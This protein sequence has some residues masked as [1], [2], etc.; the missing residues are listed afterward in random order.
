MLKSLTE[1][2]DERGKHAPRA[3]ASQTPGRRHRV[4]VRATSGGFACED[5]NCEA[6]R[7]YTPPHK[8]SDDPRH[9]RW[10]RKLG[11][12]GRPGPHLRIHHGELL[13]HELHGELTRASLEQG[14]EIEVSFEDDAV[15][16]HYREISHVDG[17]HILP[18]QIDVKA[19]SDWPHPISLQLIS[20]VPPPPRELGV[21]HVTASRHWFFTNI[22][23]SH[24]RGQINEFGE[25]TGHGYVIWGGSQP[26]HWETRYHCKPTP[27]MQRAALTNYNEEAARLRAGTVLH[28]GRF[29]K[30]PVITDIS[31]FFAH[32]VQQG[33]DDEEGDEVPSTL[34]LDE[35][36]ARNARALMGEAYKTDDKASFL[37]NL[38]NLRLRFTMMHGEDELRT[39]MAD[40][41]PMLRPKIH[42]RL[43]IYF[44]PL[45]Q[46]KLPVLVAAEEEEEVVREEVEE[47]EDE[48]D[49]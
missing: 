42:V 32:L 30:I 15:L 36:R 22:S 49:D 12:E 4:G 48:E 23:S 17:F 31:T 33:G 39:A 40:S 35:S 13:V 20:D 34:T 38:K 14:H 16:R 45:V 18:T 47:D 24:Q 29:N 7:H 41:T 1:N 6:C 21:E 9:T 44:I 27:E 5:P 10:S 25:E 11:P 46:E 43:R 37:M 28:I 3:L 26:A 8:D 2:K 19:D